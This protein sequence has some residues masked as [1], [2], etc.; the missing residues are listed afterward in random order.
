MMIHTI[1]NTEYDVQFF[2]NCIALKGFDSELT[3]YKDFLQ[4]HLNDPE[5]LDYEMDNTYY[6]RLNNKIDDII[7]YFRRQFKSD[8]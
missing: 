8:I 7:I 4:K 5:R 1:F 6:K 2:E 3:F